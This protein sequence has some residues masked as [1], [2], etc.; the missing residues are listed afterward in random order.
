VVVA[1]QEND[2]ENR[3]VSGLFEWDGWDR[4]FSAPV[5]HFLNDDLAQ[6]ILILSRQMSVHDAAP[7]QRGAPR[8]SLRRIGSVSTARCW[9]QGLRF[10]SHGMAG[11]ALEATFPS[12]ATRNVLLA[13]AHLPGLMRGG[14]KV[15]AQCLREGLA[16][17]AQRAGDELRRALFARAEARWRDDPHGQCLPD[18]AGLP[19]WAGAL[20]CTGPGAPALRLLARRALWQLLSAPG[21]R[22]SLAAARLSGAILLGDMSYTASGDAGA[23]AEEA[24]GRAGARGGAGH[25]PDALQRTS[26]RLDAGEL[27][28]WAPR[29]AGF[30]EGVRDRGPQFPPT[31]LLARGRDVACVRAAAAPGTVEGE[32]CAAPPAGSN[33]TARTAPAGVPAAAPQRSLPATHRPGGGARRVRLVRKEGRDVSS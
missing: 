28:G 1:L 8:S 32:G 29:A 20:L 26:A 23:R 18:V 3:T 25:A 27:L 7:G 9:M 11:L 16:Q 22:G 19:P 5:M 6:H 17:L 21:A 24:G 4:H 15:Q 30:T 2:L 33:E 31:C 13:T 14:S 12:G 10:A